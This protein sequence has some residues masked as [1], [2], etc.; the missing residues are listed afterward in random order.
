[1]RASFSIPTG[2]GSLRFAELME[3]QRQAGIVH[4]HQL[5]C[6]P[7]DD[8]FILNSIDL[9]VDGS[10]RR[11]L[12]SGVQ[13]S[14]E[15]TEVDTVRTNTQIRSASQAFEIRSPGG[16]RAHGAS[17]ANFIPKSVY[18]R[19]RGRGPQV[20]HAAERSLASDYREKR[21]EILL[22]DQTD[23]LLSDHSS[24][25]ISAMSV[26]N[27]IERLAIAEAP[28][29]HVAELSLRFIAY[30]ELQPAPI[31]ELA[32]DD[33]RA[34]NG[35]LDQGGSVRATFSGRVRTESGNGAS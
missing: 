17:T 7:L 20:V 27:A 10:E 5:L 1:M 35:V 4:A 2:R 8:T 6:V 18:E 13:G 28:G 21:R 31:L 26:I 9:H 14:I 3:V 33:T 22:V 12:A 16:L 25:H 11:R 19:I 30:A 34:F 15:V 32:L 23:P 29:P 24:D